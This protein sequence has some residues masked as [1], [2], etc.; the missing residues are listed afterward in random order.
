MAKVVMP[1][2]SVEAHGTVGKAVT[3]RGGVG[4]TTAA[5]YKRQ[6]DARSAAQLARRALFSAAAA[7]WP[8]ICDPARGVLANMAV[9]EYLS[10]WNWYLRL[11]ML[12]AIPVGEV[13]DCY[14]G[15]FR[16]IG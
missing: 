14:V 8:G 13:G 5:R 7:E 2:L 11:K 9:E 12:D 4:M 16:E 3:F 10:G 15:D 6:R 1:L